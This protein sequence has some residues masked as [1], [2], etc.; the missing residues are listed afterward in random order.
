MGIVGKGSVRQ[1][2]TPVDGPATP[3]SG[4]PLGWESL[5]GVRSRVWTAAAPRSRS[6]VCGSLD[7]L[8]QWGENDTYAPTATSASGKPADK[9]RTALLWS[10]LSRLLDR[11]E[12]S[13]SARKRLRRSPQ[14]LTTIAV[15]PHGRQNPRQLQTFW[16][17]EITFFGPRRHSRAVFR[18]NSQNYRVGRLGCTE[19]HD[20]GS[21]DD[22]GKAGTIDHLA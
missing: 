18:A 17:P 6:P 12:G 1:L 16:G 3:D 14:R 8:F 19:Y 4:Y 5:S 10:L 7:L 21:S 22:G 11:Q 13:H 15:P 9:R 2:D 20:G